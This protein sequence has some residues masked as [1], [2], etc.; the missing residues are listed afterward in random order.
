MILY[1]LISLIVLTI[2][3]NAATPAL[4]ELQQVGEIRKTQELMKNLDKIISI[5]ATEGQGSSRDITIT[6]SGDELVID[7]DTDSLSI[8]TETTAKIVS[9]R[10]KKKEGNYFIAAHADMDA[11]NA[12]IGDENVLLMRNDHVYFAVKKLDTNT[13]MKL[14]NLVVKMRALDYNKDLNAKIDFYMDNAQ[15]EDVNVYTAFGKNMSGYKIGR[16][17]IIAYVHRKV[18]GTMQYNYQLH[19]VLETGMDFV[20]IYVD[21]ASW[22]G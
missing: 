13:Q 12:Q 14:K 22:G 10:Y 5:V 2:V 4:Q 19:F 11:I 17:E 15:N 3:L 6:I 21:H 9:P 8:A 1:T 20:R 18:A 16:G 7:K